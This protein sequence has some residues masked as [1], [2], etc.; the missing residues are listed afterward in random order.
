M[1][2][3]VLRGIQKIAMTGMIVRWTH[4]KEKPESVSMWTVG[5]PVMTAIYV[6]SM[7]CA[8]TEFALREKFCGTF[9]K[10]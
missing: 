4:V 9:F 3:F 6:Q 8:R 5:V 1:P 7:M 10:G 2:E